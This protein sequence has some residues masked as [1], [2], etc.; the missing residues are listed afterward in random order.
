MSLLLLRRLGLTW[1]LAN[2]GSQ[3]IQHSP[4]KLLFRCNLRV[5]ILVFYFSFH[6]LLLFF[7]YL[8]KHF[9]RG[10]KVLDDMDASGV[11]PD[12]HSFTYLISHCTSEDEINK[13]HDMMDGMGTPPTKHLHK[14][15]IQSYVACKSLERARHVVKENGT[16]DILHSELMNTLAY[17]LALHGEVEEARRVYDQ[18]L[19]SQGTIEPLTALCLIQRLDSAD[20]LKYL[21]ELLK[22][23][24]DTDLWDAGCSSI[25]LFCVRHKNLEFSRLSS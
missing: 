12:C 22:H 21:L 23:L 17:S 19:Q 4:S 7:I 24:T 11:K 9:H 3:L 13:Y 1:E 25:L 6:F 16:S 2:E 5:K 14:A 8:Q 18:V 20:N 10:L 15:L